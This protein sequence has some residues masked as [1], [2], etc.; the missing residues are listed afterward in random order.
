MVLYFLG[1]A[2]LI[3]GVLPPV[4]IIALVRVEGIVMIQF[5]EGFAL[6]WLS[7][8]FLLIAIIKSGEL[9]IL[10]RSCLM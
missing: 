7:L 2:H 10:I 9:V 1:Q 3:G 8:D 6:F 4:G 5:E